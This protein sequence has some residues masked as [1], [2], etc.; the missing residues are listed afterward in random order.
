M[1]FWLHP[2]T[3]LAIS[4]L[5]AYACANLWLIVTILSSPW[6]RRQDV[7]MRQKRK[8]LKRLIKYLEKSS[9]L[10]YALELTDGYSGLGKLFNRIADELLMELHFLEEDLKK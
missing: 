10:A 1:R 9:R 7:A 2:P 4:I 8:Q 6:P 3:W 5:G